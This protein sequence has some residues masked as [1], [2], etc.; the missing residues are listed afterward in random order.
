[1]NLARADVERSG[2]FIQSLERGLLVIN[3]FSRDHPSQTLSE[4]AERTGLTRATSRRILLTL[5][6]LGYVDQKGRAFALT[7]KVLD[8]G[9][10]FLSSFHV[11]EVAQPPLERLVEEVHESSSMSV[12]DG[13]DIVYVARVPTTRIM[14]IALALGSRLPAYPTSMGRVLLAGLSDADLDRY[15][16]RA[17]FERLTPHTITSPKQ[18][19]A[20]IRSV[21]SDGYALVDQELEEGVR[22][23]AAP[24]HNGRG[25]VVAAMNVS[26]HASRVSVE[27]MHEELKPRLLS[28]ASEISERVVALPI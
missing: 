24:I 18:I 11:V 5:S 8:L 15:M 9:Y 13:T 10:S 26:C 14:T 22:S 1:M 25:E 12:L 4:V 23:I 27:R 3:S 17:T 28:T 6:D 21:R 16:D 19:R 2:D 20:V 7:P